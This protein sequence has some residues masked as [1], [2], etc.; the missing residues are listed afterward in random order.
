MIQRFKWIKDLNVKQNKSTKE[1]KAANKEICHNLRV[2]K[3]F[4]PLL[5]DPG[6]IEEKKDNLNYIK[7]YC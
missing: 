2:E 5:H 3:T 1:L 4:L 6:V 7:K